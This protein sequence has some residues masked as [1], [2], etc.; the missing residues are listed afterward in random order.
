M[1]PLL[2][3]FYINDLDLGFCSK[4]PKFFDDAK[5]GIDA[6]D[7]ESVRAL[8]RDVAVTEEWSTVWQMPFNLD[9]SHDQ[10]LDIASQ[11]ENYSLLGS[12][13]SSIDE[14]ARIQELVK[15]GALL[16]IFF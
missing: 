3:I 15:G 16:I 7:P 10:H 8:Q 9:K 11:A 14:Q 5:L 1:G 4:M 2:F 6:T 12:E 13:I